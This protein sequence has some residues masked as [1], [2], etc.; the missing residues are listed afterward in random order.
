MPSSVAVAVLVMLVT[1][2]GTAV[3]TRTETRRVT[4][5][6]AARLPMFQVTTPAA[7]TPPSEAVTKRGVGGQGVGEDDAG[8]PLVAR[9]ADGQ[10]VDERLPRL[11]APRT[12]R[13]GDLQVRRGHE[14]VRVD[15]RVVQGGGVRAVGPVVTD[16]RLVG[17]LGH[18]GRDGA[19]DH[20]R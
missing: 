14:R 12:V 5:A 16:A 3:S 9:V 15:G 6:P 2:A 8:G 4:V 10:G 20:A 17:D 18:A 7:K 1:P 19:V 11:S 13:L